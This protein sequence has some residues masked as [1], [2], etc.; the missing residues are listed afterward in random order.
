MVAD[1]STVGQTGR[2][3]QT[4]L[5][6]IAVGMIERVF[7]ERGRAMSLADLIRAW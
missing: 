1:A 3:R 2:E 4:G 5:A 6:R 7:L